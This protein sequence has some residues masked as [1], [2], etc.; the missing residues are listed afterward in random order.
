[1]RY[2]KDKGG[3]YDTIITNIKKLLSNGCD[4][5]LRIN[6]TKD[7][8]EGVTAIGDDLKDITEEQKRHLSIDFQRVWQDYES[9]TVDD[10]LRRVEKVEDTFKKLGLKISDKTPDYVRDS[11]YGNK[12]NHALVNFNGDVYNCTARDFTPQNRSGILTEEGGIIW[13]NDS[14]ERRM[15]IRLRRSACIRCNIAPLCG[16]GCSQKCLEN[17]D[18]GDFCL[19]GNSDERKKYI[20]LQRFEGHIVRKKRILSTN[21]NIVNQ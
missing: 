15:G 2:S 3:S 16:G 10:I 6:Y 17:E 9:E 14:M 20:V 13:E 12:R 7:N 4:V 21:T 1:V 5:I 8:I 11:C 18:D 19:Y